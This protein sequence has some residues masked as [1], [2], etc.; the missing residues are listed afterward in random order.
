M[1]KARESYHT[2]LALVK[3]QPWFLSLQWK[4]CLWTELQPSFLRLQWKICPWAKHWWCGILFYIIFILYKVCFNNVNIM[5]FSINKMQLIN[6]E[7]LFSKRASVY[8]LVRWIFVGI[9]ILRVH[10]PFSIK[11]SSLPWLIRCKLR[12]QLWFP[13]YHLAII[14]IISVLLECV[15]ECC[16]SSLMFVL[17]WRWPRHSADHSSGEALH[18]L[19]WSKKYVGLCDTDINSLPRQVVA[20]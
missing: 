18:V 9:S 14:L 7:S 13:E 1:R 17:S 5:Q 6:L 11:S 2:Y 16:V 3:L 10:A 19:V 12:N 20:L 15:S 8:F 4:T